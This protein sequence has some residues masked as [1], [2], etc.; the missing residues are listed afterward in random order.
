[1]EEKK[2]RIT[3]PH[4]SCDTPNCNAELRVNHLLFS[5]QSGIATAFCTCSAGHS[6][7]LLCEVTEDKPNA[8]V[9]LTTKVHGVTFENP[10]GTNRQA[11]LRHVKSGDQIKVTQ[12]MLNNRKALLVRHDIGVLGTIRSEQIY[13]AVGA[14]LPQEGFEGKVV[15]TTGGETGKATL[16][17]I[18][19]LNL[20][21]TQ[22]TTKNVTQNERDTEFIKNNQVGSS[23]YVYV[24]R[25]GR[26]IYHKDP[27]CSGM[28]K[29]ERQKI[30]YAKNVLKAR[31]CKR[32]AL[33]QREQ[34]H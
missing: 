34:E 5:S 24:D 1:M 7:E 28:K 30:E 13:E 3:F 17:C 6:T 21:T 19:E 16:G 14:V 15:R 32:C 11:L 31:A 4:L 27:H 10:D 25:D 29:A 26:N 12:G 18:V 33:E 9:R 23:G 8:P 20:H 2:W 22:S